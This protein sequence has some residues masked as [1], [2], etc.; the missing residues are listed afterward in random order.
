MTLLETWEY[1]TTCL[2]IRIRSTSL[3]VNTFSR[4]KL[5]TL[6]GFHCICLVLVFHLHLLY[7]QCTVVTWYI[8][9]DL[10]KVSKVKIVGEDFLYSLFYSLIL[11]NK[12]ILIKK[13]INTDLF[14]SYTISHL[15]K[16][17]DTKPCWFL[18]HIDTWR[19]QKHSQLSEHQ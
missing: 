12:K 4:S 14:L 5:L 15:K 18:K 13:V 6:S 3:K 16:L 8:F 19:T 10:Q 1:F 7:V 9:L 2:W 11:I 17:V